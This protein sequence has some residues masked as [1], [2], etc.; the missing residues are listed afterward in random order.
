[1]IWRS[2]SP[3]GSGWPGSS[4]AVPRPRRCGDES[5][6]KRYRGGPRSSLAPDSPPSPPPHAGGTRGEGLGGGPKRL[7]PE[8]GMDYP[9]AS[10]DRRAFP[11]P[12]NRDKTGP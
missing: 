10:A 11:D 1:M 6:G 4:T 7:N 8:S 9:T 3:P 12:T 5:P 2:A